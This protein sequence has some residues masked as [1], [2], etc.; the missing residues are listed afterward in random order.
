MDQLLAQ[1][2][3]TGGSEDLE[4]TAQAIML[5]K[6]AEQEQ[7]DLSQFSPEEL[8]A[9]QQEVFAGNGGQ[10]VDPQQ[11]QLQQQLQGQGGF[12][13]QAFQPQGQGLQQGQ[14]GFDMNPTQPQFD[15]RQQMLQ[16]QQ[17]QQQGGIPQHLL[18]QVSQQLLQQQGQQGQFP[19]QAQQGGE[20][21]GVLE[22]MAVKEAQAKFEEADF[23]GRV[24]AHSCHQEMQKIAGMQKRASMQDGAGIDE[25]LAK[26]QGVRRLVEKA[27][28][29]VSGAGG[30]LA[31]KAKSLG[32][33]ASDAASNLGYKAVGAA[34]RNP[35]AALGIGAGALAAGAGAGYLAGRGGKEKNAFDQLAEQR[36]VQILAENGVQNGGQPAPQ[37]VQQVQQ[38][39]QQLQPVQ[40]AQQPQVTQQQFGEALEKRAFELLAQA[41]Y[42]G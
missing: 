17:A 40:Q 9:L 13:P 4:K 21:Q 29:A 27:K 24:M 36:A 23:L 31:S 26:Q 19:Q 34:S 38:A 25:A 22:E 30:A 8:E 32:G 37:Q 11:A 1:I 12:N 39:P 5:E 7:V 42:L 20:E 41:G 6:L 18:E 16:L 2:Y 35:K 10:Q 33:Q 14:P 3:G 15:P 28:G